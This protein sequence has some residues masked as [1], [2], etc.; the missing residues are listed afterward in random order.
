MEKPVACGAR[1]TLLA[2]SQQNQRRVLEV[3]KVQRTYD[4]TLWYSVTRRPQQNTAWT[5]NPD[6][7]KN[8]LVQNL[9]ESENNWFCHL[10]SPAIM[11]CM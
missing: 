1:G 10:G 4:G 8:I 5:E 3:G 11:N 2:H 7:P 6:P 9:S